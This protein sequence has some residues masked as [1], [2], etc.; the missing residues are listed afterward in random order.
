MRRPPGPGLT[1]WMV[2]GSPRRAPCEGPAFLVRQYHRK[3]CY[4]ALLHI[5][6]IFLNIEYI[7]TIL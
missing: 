1:A 4:R 7:K 2:S 3:G 5:T 6:V